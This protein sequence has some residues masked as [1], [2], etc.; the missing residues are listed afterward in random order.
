MLANVSIFFLI[1]MCSYLQGKIVTLMSYYCP[2]SG[3]F[4]WCC[5]WVWLLLSCSE[6]ALVILG[7]IFTQFFSPNVGMAPIHVIS[8]DRSSEPLLTQ[9]VVNNCKILMEVDSGAGV[10]MFPLIIFT[11]YF[12]Q[13]SFDTPYVQTLSSATLRE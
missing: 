4:L 7:F 11:T 3:V 10:T 2:V 9:V 8:A 12:S 1:H 5:F 6:A 13:F